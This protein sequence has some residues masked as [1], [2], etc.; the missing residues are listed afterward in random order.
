MFWIMSHWVQLS[1]AV[2]DSPTAAL[3]SPA[4]AGHITEAP[5][6]PA[7]H[8]IGQA[9]QPPDR[10][11][12]EIRVRAAIFHGP[13]THSRR[14]RRGGTDP[15][16]HARFPASS[17]AAA[18]DRRPCPVRARRPGLV[19]CA[20]PVH[21]AAAMGRSLPGDTR[22]TAGLAP[23]TG[24]AEVRHQ[25]APPGRPPAGRA[26][27]HPDRRPPGE[28]EPAVRLPLDPRRADQTRSHHRAVDRL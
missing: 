6:A 25:H 19:H 21:P 27:H 14:H 18:P 7:A 8:H 9:G 23:Q 2:P 1:P 28:G 24:R 17:P 4:P 11:T 5:T 16:G 12:S 15:H 20:G 26:E 13:A 22:D 10:H 3:P